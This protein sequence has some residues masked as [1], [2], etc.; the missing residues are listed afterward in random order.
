M[1][2]QGAEGAPPQRQL[3]VVPVSFQQ[4]R[5][6]VALWHRHNEPPNGHRFSIGVAAGE[7]LV[8]VAIVMLAGRRR[9]PAEEVELGTSP[10]CSRA[11]RGSRTS[12]SS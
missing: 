1:S 8:G 2:G 5:D 12:S 6:F 7:E 4:A 3:R 9:A 11:R 10:S